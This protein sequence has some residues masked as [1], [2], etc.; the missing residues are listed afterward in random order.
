MAAGAGADTAKADP[1]AVARMAG[2][3]EDSA[4]AGAVVGALAGAAAG[5]F[6]MAE[7][8]S[9]AG[10]EA[11][12]ALDTLRSFFGAMLQNDARLPNFRST[13]P[14]QVR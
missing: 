4:A 11:A 8:L 6:E 10:E 13:S 3:F 12:G 1:G 2:T 5:A 14:K 7:P 9:G